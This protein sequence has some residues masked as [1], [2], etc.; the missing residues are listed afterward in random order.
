MSFLT[1]AE[2][3]ASDPRRSFLGASGLLLSG[4]AIALLAGRDALAK[5]GSG[6]TADDVRVLNSALG[7]ELEAVAAYQ[8]GAESGLLRKPA[9]DLAEDIVAAQTAQIEAMQG[10]TNS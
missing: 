10:L 9:L 8:L 2:T 3:P 1:L 5:S 7:A 6:S 4:T